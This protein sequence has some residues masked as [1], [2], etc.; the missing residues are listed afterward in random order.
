[1]STSTTPDNSPTPS[2][3]LPDEHFTARENSPL[4]SEGAIAR[5][6]TIDPLLVGDAKDG[7]RRISLG[8]I[9]PFPHFSRSVFSTSTTS[10]PASYITVLTYLEFIATFEFVGFT[11][12]RATILWGERIK[13]I[14]KTKCAFDDK[15]AGL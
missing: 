7:K 11:P 6:R 13:I 3:A 1:M 8:L 12:Q 2:F 14:Q 10:N 5:L 4:L 15:G 9:A